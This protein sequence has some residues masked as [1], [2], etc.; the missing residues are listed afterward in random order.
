[1]A[2]IL[3]NP[4]V[5]TALIFLSALL[6]FNFIGFLQPVNPMINRVFP[7]TPSVSCLN[8]PDCTLAIPS[9]L[10]ECRICDPYDCRMHSDSEEGVVAIRK[11]WQPR[12]IFWQPPGECISAC[13]GGVRPGEY[14]ARCADGLCVKTRKS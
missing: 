11:D 6:T 13:I 4:T 5:I 3:N 10:S 12:C 2:G 9:E 14:E 8:D 1:M 7:D